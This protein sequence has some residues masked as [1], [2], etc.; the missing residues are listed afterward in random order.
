MVAT[1]SVALLRGR[2]SSLM[3]GI[4]R[5]SIR[6][7]PLAETFISDGQSAYPEIIVRARTEC[8]KRL[9]SR[10]LWQP[11]RGRNWGVSISC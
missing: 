11:P 1:K 3:A 5:Q 8:L 4:R 6:E 9:T 10:K 7:R 2:K